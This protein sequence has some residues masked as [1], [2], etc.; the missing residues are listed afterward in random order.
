MRNFDSRVAT[1]YALLTRD[2]N[3]CN[4]NLIFLNNMIYFEVAAGRFIK[5]TLVKCQ[6]LC[7]RKLLEAI[8]V[9]VEDTLMQNIEHLLSA[10]KQ[11]E[12]L[13]KSRRLP[14]EKKTS[15]SYI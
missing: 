13:M 11:R 4:T 10:T 12:K 8:P 6:R 14:L 1:N 2:L 7:E 3:S 15:W 9:H 5:D